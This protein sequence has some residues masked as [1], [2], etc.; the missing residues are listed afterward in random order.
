MLIVLLFESP[1]CDAVSRKVG[2]ETMFVSCTQEDFFEIANLST[3]WI[4]I[5]PKVITVT[6]TRMAHGGVLCLGRQSQNKKIRQEKN[7]RMG[8]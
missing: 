6:D 1:L 3:L 8:P 5:T 7:I 2:F 4:A